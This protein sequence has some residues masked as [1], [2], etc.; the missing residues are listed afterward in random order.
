MAHVFEIEGIFGNYFI[1][2]V[3]VEHHDHDAHI[4]VQDGL[5]PFWAGLSFGSISD[6]ARF[7]MC[8][9]VPPIDG[10]C[11]FH[12][13]SFEEVDSAYIPQVRAQN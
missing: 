12:G 1:A 9:V 10:V 11:K 4:T 13:W 2:A 8:N 5:Q 7:G 3:R 6:R